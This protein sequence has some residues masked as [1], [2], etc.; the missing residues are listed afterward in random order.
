M[1]VY[2]CILY[3]EYN[4][5]HAGMRLL[6]FTLL[7]LLVVIAIIAILASL[8]MPALKNARE[9]SKKTVCLS[10][11]K[12]IGIGLTMYINDY[13][14]WVPVSYDGKKYFD[15]KIE[16]VEDVQR[17]TKSSP[18]L[19]PS[20]P[21]KYSGWTS[22][23]YHYN[24]YAWNIA[25]GSQTLQYK[26]TAFAKPSLSICISDGATGYMGDENRAWNWI[27]SSK[28][29]QVG[30]WHNSVHNFLYLDTHAA[31]KRSFVPTDLNKNP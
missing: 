15:Q 29:E 5:G 18:W 7:E 19:C 27:G 22:G 1:H 10:N 12:Q 4:M 30:N 31:A 24:N 26:I 28:P 14:S 16:I 21:A 9:S 17:E 25:V 11:M 13:Q 20:S 2:A 3:V 6:K 8:L 23:G